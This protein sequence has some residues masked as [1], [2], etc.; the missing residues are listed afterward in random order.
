MAFLQVVGPKGVLRKKTRLMRHV[1]D[2]LNIF[3]PSLCFALCEMFQLKAMNIFVLKDLGDPWDWL[4]A[5]GGQ[6]HSAEER[7]GEK[8]FKKEAKKHLCNFVVKRELNIF[9]L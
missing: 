4:P 7:G 9:S 2:V 1:M 3:I 6:D 8:N 5:G